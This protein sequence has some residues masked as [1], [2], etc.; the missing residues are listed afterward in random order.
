MLS[1]S[2]EILALLALALPMLVAIVTA[3]TADTAVKTFV[4][5][6]L[7]AAV[8]TVD[9]LRGSADV[10]WR[11]LLVTTLVTFGSSVLAHFGLLKP[12][13]VTGSDGVIAKTLPPGIGGR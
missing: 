12:V 2:P 8:T 13:R 11:A 10:S 4:L 5:L 7:S 3:K 6:A 1:L 9:Q